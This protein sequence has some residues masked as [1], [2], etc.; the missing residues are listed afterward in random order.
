MNTATPPSAPDDSTL[1]HLAVELDSDALRAVARSTVDDSAVLAVTV[2]LDPSAP[3]P[4]KALEDAVYSTPML[5]ADYRS[6]TVAV[7]TTAYTLCADVLGDTCADACAD[8]CA[9]G[10]DGLTLMHDAIAA[11]GATTVWAVADDILNFVRRTFHNCTIVHHTTPLLRYFAGRRRAGNGGKTYAHFH[12]G[13]PAAVDIIIFDGD[14]HF[15]LAATKIINSDA[16]AMYYILAAARACGAD[17]AADSI[18]LCGDGARR[19]ALMPLLRRYVASVMPV[20]FPA[21]AFRGGDAALK[22]PFP[23]I[24]MPLCE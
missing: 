16:D 15:A 3:A 12:A 2:A 18:C 22:A 8:I 7:R 17:P 1:W 13:N 19:A 9:I 20:I 4:L 5:L 24:L 14:G 6:V 11:A 10:G 21:A 23:L